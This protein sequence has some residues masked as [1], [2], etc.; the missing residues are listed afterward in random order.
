[1]VFVVVAEGEFTV[2]VWAGSDFVGKTGDPFSSTLFA[3]SWVSGPCFPL[4]RGVESEEGFM[5]GVAQE[6]EKGSS[7]VDVTGDFGASFSRGLREH[8]ATHGDFDYERIRESGT[9]NVGGV[10]SFEGEFNSG[11]SMRLTCLTEKVKRVSK[12][13]IEG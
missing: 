2:V 12:M 13:R 6:G 3:C 9:I 4:L 1:M 11:K 8:L 7:I 5:V 10:D